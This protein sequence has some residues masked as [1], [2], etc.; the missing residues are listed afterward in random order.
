MENLPKRLD[1]SNR[2]IKKMM[3]CEFDIEIVFFMCV[4]PFRI[5]YEL[6]KLARIVIN[7]HR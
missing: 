4:K 5:E 3:Q 2:N 6:L 7:P 1:D